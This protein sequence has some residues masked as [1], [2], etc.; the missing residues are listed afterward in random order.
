[1]RT[2][3][4][5]QLAAAALVVDHERI[6]SPGSPPAPAAALDVL[7]SPPTPLVLAAVASPPLPPAPELVL[8]AAAE[9]VT[10]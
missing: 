3:A 4:A 6:P 7:P 8:V 1:V 2:C 5:R 9:P 10:T